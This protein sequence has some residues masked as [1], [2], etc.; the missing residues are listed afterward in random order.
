[1]LVMLSLTIILF[2]KLTEAFNPTTRGTEVTPQMSTEQTMYLPADKDV[3]VPF[4]IPLHNGE[5]RNKPVLRGAD[6]FEVKWRKEVSE[7]GFLITDY[8][9]GIFAVDSDLNLQSL[10]T[11]GNVLW[12]INLAK[13]GVEWLPKLYFGKDQLLYAFAEPNPEKEGSKDGLIL[14]F[15]KKGELKRT[16]VV[17]GV[18]EGSSESNL[19]DT[20]AKGNLV[21][22][23]ENGLIYIDGQSNQTLWTNQQDVKKVQEIA[24][25]RHVL[26][27]DVYE[28]KMDFQGNVYVFKKD[29]SL[30][31]LNA[32]GK[33]SW[34]IPYALFTAEKYFSPAGLIYFVGEWGITTLEL[35]SGAFMATHMT[36]TI[37]NE[38]NIPDDGAGGFYVFA[39]GQKG[40]MNGVINVDKNGKVKWRYDKKDDPYF[41]FQNLVADD[42]GNLF[43]TSTNGNLYSLTKEGK[44]QFVLIRN[45]SVYTPSI[46]VPVQLKTLLC[47]TEDIGLIM[48]GPKK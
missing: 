17:P 5:K 10:D 23:T 40:V 15:S 26:G 7:G 8:Q 22:L 6:H 39:H 45:N 38:L 47:L 35:S 4:E 16:I 42:E 24:G 27:S 21:T 29:D 13:L 46:I 33:K 19:F 12:K 44:E 30:L 32:S 9:G 34:Q 3:P 2:P 36:P 11:K 18:M 41:P 43:F 1:M 31:K 37:A 28:L 20:D 25:K 14:A 48:V